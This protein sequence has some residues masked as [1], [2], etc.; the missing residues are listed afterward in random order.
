MENKK[1]VGVRVEVVK[2]YEDLKERLKHNSRFKTYKSIKNNNGIISFDENHNAKSVLGINSEFS[3]EEIDKAFVYNRV[4]DRW[5]RLHK[6]KQ[7]KYLHNTRSRAFAEGIL[8]FSEGI[9]QDYEKDPKKFQEKVTIFIKDFEKTHKTK[10]HSYQIHLDEENKKEE[11]GNYHVHFIFENFDH[12]TGKAL[13]FTND[14]DQGAL[15]QD[16]GFKHFKDFGQGYARGEK[17]EKPSRYIPTHEYIKLKEFERQN[18]EIQAKNAELKKENT[19]L[20]TKYN[21]VAN[22]FKIL[23]SRNEALTIQNEA[24]ATEYEA[25][26][27]EMVEKLTE[28][29]QEQT[30]Q[31]FSE[32]FWRYF[33]DNNGKGKEK[34]DKLIEKYNYKIEKLETKACNHCHGTKKNGK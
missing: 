12:E 20:E 27:M 2:G 4:F 1:Y 18:K 10:V 8:Y 14:K 6:E 11:K 26:M 17:K 13:N 31:K 34:I 7:G 33:K 25:V 9:N 3:K 19:E 5:K 15:I 21:K 32:L 30:A 24:V 16:L 23:K 29:S 28:L 22:N